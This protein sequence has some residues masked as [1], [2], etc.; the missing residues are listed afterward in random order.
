MAIL[1]VFLSCSPYDKYSH[2]ISDPVMAEIIETNLR[3]M[4]VPLGESLTLTCRSIGNPVPKTFW[5][6]VG[7]QMTN[8]S[9]YKLFKRNCTT[10]ISLDDLFSLNYQVQI[11]CFNSNLVVTTYTT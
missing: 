1:K 7:T 4:E 6:K 5:Y 3:I 8:H 11:K 9:I 10:F 2:C